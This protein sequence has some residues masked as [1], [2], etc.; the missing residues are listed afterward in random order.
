[1]G[2]SYVADDRS[3]FMDLTVSENPPTSDA[4]PCARRGALPGVGAAGLHVGSSGL[5]SRPSVECSGRGDH[6]PVSPWVGVAVV[7]WVF[8]HTPVRLSEWK[9]ALSEA[10]V[11]WVPKI[12]EGFGVR[13]DS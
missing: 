12:T 2:L 1:M 11:S 6:G 9:I 10:G 8:A 5:V 13:P 3:L 7:D 4:S